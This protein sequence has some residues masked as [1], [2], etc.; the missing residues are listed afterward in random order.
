MSTKNPALE[1]LFEESSCVHLKT[2]F[3]SGSIQ[4]INIS[5]AAPPHSKKM[6]ATT[7]EQLTKTF[8]LEG[9]I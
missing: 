9:Q 4:K 6:C 7:T 2:S 3:E 5:I 8:V 1:F